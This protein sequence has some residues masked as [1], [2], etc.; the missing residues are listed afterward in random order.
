MLRSRIASRSQC[1]VVNW[2]AV[3]RMFSPFS[4]LPQLSE[5][6]TSVDNAQQTLSCCTGANE[7]KIKLSLQSRIYRGCI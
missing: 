2:E 7:E 4:M 3:K 6:A 5:C 1:F